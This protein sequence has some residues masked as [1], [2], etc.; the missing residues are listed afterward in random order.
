MLIPMKE[1]NR[2]TPNIDNKMSSIYYFEDGSVAIRLKHLDFL[3]K[4]EM[5][6]RYE[7]AKEIGHVDGLE[8]PFDILETEKGFCG[9]IERNVY[10]IGGD[11][12][13]SFA[14]Y[15]NDHHELGLN[16]ISE[17]VLN[18]AKTTD[19]AT[20]N[21][22]IMTDMPTKGNVLYNP[23]TGSTYFIDYHDM[24]VRDIPAR[25]T[26]ELVV[27]DPFLSSPKYLSGDMA[28]KELNNYILATRYFYYCTK[29]YIFMNLRNNMTL[30]EI[31]DD[32]GLKN[33][34]LADYMKIVY[35][36]NKHNEDITPMINEMVKNYELTE[37][38]PHLPRRFIR[39]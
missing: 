11:N 12:L 28:T 35:D 19:Q 3:Q 20:E 30:D 32:V 33:S 36:H 13:T 23:D 39:K 6:K 26:N 27:A 1:L 22:I 37:F 9:F 25:G 29:V 17:Y 16:T 7:Y 14:S 18:C 38:K 4:K 21:E 24:Q 34:P 31:M 8:L 15:Y 2:M 10:K 5:L